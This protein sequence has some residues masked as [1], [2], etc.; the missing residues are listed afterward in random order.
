[1]RT[2]APPLASRTAQDTAPAPGAVPVWHSSPVSTGQLALAVAAVALVVVLVIGLSPGAKDI[3]A[4]AG[5]DDAQRGRDRARLGGAPPPLAA[6]HRQANQILPGGAQG[7]ARAA[8]RA[9][10]P[11][12]VVNI[13]AAWCG[14]CR[15]EMPGLPAR[16]ARPGQA[17]RVPRRRPQGQQGR[18]DDVPAEDPGDLPELRG[19][20]GPGLQRREA[21]RRAEHALL[22]QHGKQTFVHQ[23][24]YF[25]RAALVDDIRRYALDR[26]GRSRSSRR[27]R[28]LLVGDAR[29]PR[30]PADGS[31]VDR[32]GRPRDA[33]RRRAHAPSPPRRST[34]RPTRSSRA[35]RTARRPRST[36]CARTAARPDTPGLDGARR[37]QPL[38]RA[39]PRER[40]TPPPFAKPRPVHRA[41]RPRRARGRRQR[42]RSRCTS[43]AELD[44]RAGR[45]PR[46]TCG[47]SGCAP[48][49][50]TPPTCT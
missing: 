25:D 17:G 4:A 8:R 24:P 35:T 22:R 46:S 13:W 50:A 15:A 10:G 2:P 3:R 21:R 48:R 36:R 32:R 39:R 23:G 34:P 28:A 47:A 49:R 31:E 40:R 38:P 43:L 16:L 6:L 12:A 29:G 11:P 37:A 5:G 44:G 19:P 33:P 9:Q 14:P 7:P 1:M 26:R 41:A 20:H 18:R 30:R 45:A 27:A 42:A